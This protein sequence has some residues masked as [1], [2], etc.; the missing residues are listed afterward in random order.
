MRKP[1][2]PEII[3]SLEADESEG[4]AA[5]LAGEF[6]TDPARADGRVDVAYSGGT[7]EYFDGDWRPV[8]RMLNNGRNREGKTE[9]HF[10]MVDP[11]LAACPPPPAVK[12]T[13]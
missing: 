2:Q 11:E 8:D 13:D 5:Q 3:V 9:A 12:K 7:I 4:A 6:K 1:F 10:F